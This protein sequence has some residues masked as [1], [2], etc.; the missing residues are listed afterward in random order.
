LVVNPDGRL[1]PCAMVMAYFN[2]HR[3]MQREFSR[4]NTCEA[5]FIST[6][7]HAEKTV[8]ESLADNVDTLRLFLPWNWA[9]RR[10]PLGPRRA[11]DAPTMDAPR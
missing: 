2:D 9:R 5:C 11:L 10:A 4:T 8:Q 6:R 7:A 3:T 1:T